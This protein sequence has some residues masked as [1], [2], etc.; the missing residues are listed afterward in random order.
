M[1]TPYAYPRSATAIIIL[2]SL[3]LI[4]TNFLH[5][6]V[7]TDLTLSELNAAAQTYLN[8]GLSTSTRKAY[9]TGLHK[10]IT[11]C[12]ETNHRPVPVCE[13]K[14]LLFATYLAQRHLSCP[15]IQV[16]LSAV[17]HS[18]IITGKSLPL[19]TPRLSYVLKGI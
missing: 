5:V 19:A 14:L 18:Q 6:F 13:E 7:P 12:T 10:Y 11:F 9:K 17:R 4:I 3:I 16:Y 2:L 15:T 8:L 1:H